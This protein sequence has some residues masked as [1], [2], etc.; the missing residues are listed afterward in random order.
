M[1]KVARTLKDSCFQMCIDTLSK[2][3]ILDKCV[4]NRTTFTITLPNDSV[5]LFT[6]SWFLSGGIG[7]DN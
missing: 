1:R 2:F 3:K 5:L 4:I 7:F 6:G